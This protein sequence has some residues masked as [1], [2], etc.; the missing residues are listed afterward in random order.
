MANEN[1]TIKKSDFDFER[2][3]SIT[4]VILINTGKVLLRILSYAMNVILTVLL[5]GLI[6]GVIGGT[7]FAV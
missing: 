7:V 5:I 6:C 2:F 3:W 4:K 1:E